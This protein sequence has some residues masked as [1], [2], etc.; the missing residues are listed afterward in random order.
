MASRIIVNNEITHDSEAPESTDLL[1]RELVEAEAKRNICEFEMEAAEARLKDVR[2]RIERSQR[3]AWF[4]EQA[5]RNKMKD[6][7]LLSPSDFKQVFDPN[8]VNDD[9]A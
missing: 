1:N 8:K 3:Q 2:Q 7:L 9:E 4:N 6:A 5:Q